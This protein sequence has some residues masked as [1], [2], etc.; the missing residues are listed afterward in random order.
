MP[1]PMTSAANPDVLDRRFSRIFANRYK[2]LPSMLGDL[3]SMK[4]GRKGPD[5][6]ESQFGEFGD[7]ERFTGNVTYDSVAEGYDVTGTYVHYAR[8]FQVDVVL[9]EDDLFHVVDKYPSKLAVAA[10]RTREKDGARMFTM[11]FSVD[12]AFYTHSEGVALCSNSHTTRASG[13]STA[14]GFDNLTTAALSPTALIAARIQMRGFRNDRGGRINVEPNEL[15]IPPD[16]CATGY[17]IVESMG[18]PD[19]ANNAKNYLQGRYQ[20]REWNYMSDPN[21]WFICDS[22][23][24]KDSVEWFDRIPV[25]FMR[26]QDIDTFVMKYV[27]RTRYTFLWNDWRWILGAQVS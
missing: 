11:A 7:F 25:Q 15:W 26:A 10:N 17:E 21:D 3:Y 16:L 18:K 5:E 8:G 19:T 27:A 4:K 13:V 23:L 22:E 2:E 9:A 12:T 20:V 1:T 6:R 14:T 24:R